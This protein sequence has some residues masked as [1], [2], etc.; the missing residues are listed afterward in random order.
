M[1]ITIVT[2]GASGIGRSLAARLAGRGDTVIIADID[3]AGAAETADDLNGR[4]H[5]KTFAAEL[6]VT[7]AGAVH[8]LYRRTARD[9]GRL[10]LVF[11]NAGIAVAGLVEELTLAHWDRA[12]DINLKGVIHGVDAAY[13][14][15]LEQ[16]HG[17]IVNTASLA[18][19]FPMPLG[20]PYTATKHAVVG[21]GLALR[22]EAAT[23]G[24]KVST[25]CPGFV[26]TS[27]LKTVNAGLP[28]TG[29]SSKPE[30]SDEPGAGNLYSPDAMAADIMK[31]VARNRALII[32]PAT[33]RLAWRVMRI[34]PRLA[35]RLGRFA[36]KGYRKEHG[37]G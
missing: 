21:L 13:R 9:H 12:V 32:A 23:R 4:F 33:G 15:M 3:A 24:I 28:E 26:D 30:A 18:G 36:V 14:I 35:V 16:G 29:M 2:G 11:N 25:V 31:G 8:D 5:G 6:D 37:L 20:I 7:D 22:A 1:S 17:H 34:S 27:L 10:D 19:L